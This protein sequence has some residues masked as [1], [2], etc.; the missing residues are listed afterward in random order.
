MSAIIVS[1]THQYSIEELKNKIDK[2]ILD[3]QQ[4]LEFQSEWETESNL[5][6]R[7]KGANGSIDIDE[8]N[9]ELTL[10]LGMMFRALKGT[11][12][13]QIIKVVDSHLNV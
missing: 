2:I 10:R 6:F 11:I 3:I 7:R 12:E 1:R 4:E 13:R 9:F 8:N 5:V